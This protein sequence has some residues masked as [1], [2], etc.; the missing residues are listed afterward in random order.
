MEYE[1][2][3]EWDSCNSGCGTSYFYG[4]AVTPTILKAVKEL[5]TICVS[6]DIIEA[7]LTCEDT[8]EQW[9]YE[10]GPFYYGETDYRKF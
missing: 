6:G 9:I 10:V 8:G 7:T 3:V 2:C 4:N 5:K 1:I